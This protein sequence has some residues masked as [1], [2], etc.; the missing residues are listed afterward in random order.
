MGTPFDGTWID[1]NNTTIT[2]TS[3]NEILSVDYGNGRGPFT[4]VA[5]TLGGPV[6][7]VNFADVVPLAGVLTVDSR[8]VP[9]GGNTIYWAN[10]TVWNRAQAAS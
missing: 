6:L 2:V 1:Q 8:K 5:A 7:Y 9:T 4:G 3:Q 10:S